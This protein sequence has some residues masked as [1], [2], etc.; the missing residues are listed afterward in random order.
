MPSL[1]GARDDDWRILLWS[2]RGNRAA[3]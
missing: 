1:R 2:Y 3:A